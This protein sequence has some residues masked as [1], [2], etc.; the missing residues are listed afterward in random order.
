MRLRFRLVSLFVVTL[1]ALTFLLPADRTKAFVAPQRAGFPLAVP[2]TQRVG[3]G[4]P[5]LADINGDGK[6][7]I[8]VG[9]IDGQLLV[10]DSTGKLLWRYNVSNAINAAANTRPGLKQS[11]TPV[12]I[13][14]APSVGDI[15]GDGQPDIIV[16]AGDISSAN[17]HGGVMALTR[18]GQPIPGWPFISQDVSPDIRLKDGYADGVV[19]APAIG[20][21]N[22]DGKNE[23]V[24][25]SFDHYIYAL[26]S[27]A[28]YAPGW[29]QFAYDSVWSSPALADLDGDGQLDVII[30]IDAH[31]YADTQYSSADGG[32]LQVFRGN[33]TRLWRSAQDEVM[34]SSPAVA[35]LDG[36]GKLEIAAGTGNF[37]CC[38]DGTPSNEGKYFTV[39]NHDGSILWRTTLPAQVVGSPAI[40]DLNG[41][42]K[43]EVVVGAKD[44]KVYAFNGAT[45]QIRWATQVRDIFN[46]QFMP[47]PV[48][49]SPMLADYTG[50]GHDDVFI[51]LG[52]DIIVVRGSDGVQLTA[53]SNL[54]PDKPSYYTNYTIDGAPAIGDLDGNG[55]LDLVAASA[56]TNQQL[57]PINAQ[58][59]VWELP[60][61]T[62]KASWPQF[63]RT[64][65][66]RG[67]LVPRLLQTSTKQLGGL[68]ESNQTR[69]FT[70]AI[71][72]TDGSGATW[73]VQESDSDGIVS[74]SSATGGNGDNL[75][76]TVGGNK[77]A[78]RYTAELTIKS[79]G[80][81]DVTIT[82]DVTIANSVQNV[83]VPL[84]R[85]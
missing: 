83:Y 11:T 2:T 62:T 26:R 6:L 51:A 14:S 60:N 65:D 37:Y 49:Y 3:F 17:T 5:T 40:G 61:S 70:V 84:L 58:I 1:A 16:A 28:S 45:G 53:T 71:S 43:L 72:T 36:D 55:K 22:G 8:L 80:L 12:P 9:T 30:G 81:P 19:G 59:H 15:T 18:T 13:R 79:A 68:L 41:D 10:V 57:Q 47:N 82:V 48:V 56:S 24:F 7:E 66:K 25:G 78:G 54:D 31:V 77:P 75:L 29:P 85:R 34:F 42:G 50:N 20:D 4:I 33:G 35:D 21:I 44:G 23:V 74:L 27:D 32:E 63:S 67:L 76:I 46:N 38:F 52:W 73:T 39:W 64:P 69:E